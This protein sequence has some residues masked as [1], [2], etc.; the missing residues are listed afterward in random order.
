MAVVSWE[1]TG[2]GKHPVGHS[3]LYVSQSPNETKAFSIL[4]GGHAN[5]GG[6]LWLSVGG[7]LSPSTSGNPLF[8][9]LCGGS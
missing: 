5:E 7:V 8:T 4:V 9:N 2:F 3:S 6:G 1:E